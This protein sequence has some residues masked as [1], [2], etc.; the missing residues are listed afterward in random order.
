MHEIEPY[1]NW[2]ALYVSSE[3]SA[4]PFFGK[5]YSEFYCSEY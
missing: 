2:R 1:Y 3:D 4:S 5:E